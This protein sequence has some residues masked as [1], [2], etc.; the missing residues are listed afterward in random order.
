MPFQKQQLI[1][2]IETA[3]R[4][5]LYPQPVV[6]QATAVEAINK[7][8]AASYSNIKAPKRTL[9]QESSQLE[10]QLSQH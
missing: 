7:K 9:L 8:I 2:A 1:F 10:F 6:F 5:T 4:L 3:L